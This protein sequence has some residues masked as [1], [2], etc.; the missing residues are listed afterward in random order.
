MAKQTRAERKKQNQRAANAGRRQ[1]PAPKEEG[2]V[3]SVSGGEDF[4]QDSVSGEPL[5]VAA[6]SD[7]ELSDS[8]ETE[9][10]QPTKEE[11][12]ADKKAAKEKAKADKKAAKKKE[13][14]LKRERKAELLKDRPRRG[15]K[16]F[17]TLVDYLRNVK[18]E[19]KRVVWP[20]RRDV[21]KMTLI[22]IVALIFFGIIIYFVDFLITPLLVMF[23][24]LG[25]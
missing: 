19:M 3:V 22:V 9:A 12:K 24:N 11:S 6:E 15:P 23:S 4:D 5:D 8:E 14:R 17:W 2:G 18:V 21:L 10:K 16:F 1:E 25:G 13:K 20:T 7:E